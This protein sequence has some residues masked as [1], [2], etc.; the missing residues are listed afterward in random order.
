MSIRLKAACKSYEG[1]LNAAQFEG[2]A[3]HHQEF[4]SLF[5]FLH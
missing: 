4:G 3:G 2:F 5:G 1:Q